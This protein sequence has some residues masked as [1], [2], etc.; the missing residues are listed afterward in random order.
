M[1]FF[2]ALVYLHLM[3]VIGFSSEWQL[4]KV[5]LLETVNQLSIFLVVRFDVST[6]KQVNLVINNSGNQAFSM[7]STTL[8]T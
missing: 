6:K 8:Y 3:Q 2:E 7:L 5:K 1:L 4:L